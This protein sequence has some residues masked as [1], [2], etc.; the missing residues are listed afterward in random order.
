MRTLSV[1]EFKATCLSVLE[2]IKTYKRR[3]VITKHG[4]PIAEVIPYEGGV[5]EQP[6]KDTV[7]FVGDIVAPV[8]EDEWE[9]LK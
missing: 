6:L 5:K 4:R 8:S 3:V 1:S 9:A 2:E 7:Q